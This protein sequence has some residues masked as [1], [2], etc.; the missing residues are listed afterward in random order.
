MANISEYKTRR[1]KIDNLL[2][3]SGWIIKDRTRV[4]EEVDTKQSDFISAIYKTV[5]QTLKDPEKHAYADYVLLDSKGFPLAVVEAKRSSIDA[6]LGQRQAEGY[7]EDIKEQ[8]GKDIFIFLT[9]GYEI[10]FWNKPYESPRMVAGFHDRNSLERIRFQNT[11]K[12][13]FQDVPIK[14]EII[15][16]PY[17][18]EAVKRVIEGIE[19]GKRKFLLVV[20]WRKEHKAC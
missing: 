2:E 6:L 15:D 9:N 4:Y 16:R 11:Q 7:A 18:I 14:K 20:N 17:Q 5:S 13:E 8:T 3:K 12:K 10:W 1:D 19:K